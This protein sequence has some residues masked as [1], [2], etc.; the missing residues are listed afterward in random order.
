MTLPVD[1]E[2]DDYQ[3]LKTLN[4]DVQ[5]LPVSSTANH[6]DIQMKNGDY[7]NLTGKDSLR[8]A[9]CIAI[10]TRFQELDSIPLYAEFGCRAHQLIKANK[11]EMVRYEIEL[12]VSE[13]LENMRRIQEVNS[14]KVSDSDVQSYLVEF[15]VTSVNDETI[16]GSV[17]I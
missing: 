13:V 8:N 7:V 16:T 4:E 17:N 12:Y 1:Y 10:M 11:S 2:S 3:F 9:I 15:N 6:W 5:V 14:L